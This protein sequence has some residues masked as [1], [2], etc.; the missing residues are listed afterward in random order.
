MVMA[1]VFAVVVAATVPSPFAGADSAAPCPVMEIEGLPSSQDHCNG[2]FD[3][4]GSVWK[5]AYSVRWYYKDGDWNCDDDSDSTEVF[6]YIERPSSE[7]TEGSQSMAAKYAGSSSGWNSATITMTCKQEAEPPAAWVQIVVG[8][9]GMICCA[10][11][12]FKLRHRLAWQCF[13]MLFCGIPGCLGLARD[14]TDAAAPAAG[15]SAVGTGVPASAVPVG[16]ATAVPVH[17]T[18]VPVPVASAV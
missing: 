15:A 12:I 2:E 3:Q 6:A 8:I 5:G 16:V 11:V 1:I 4:E 7:L 9:L 17:A 13:N 14:I 18:A 10:G